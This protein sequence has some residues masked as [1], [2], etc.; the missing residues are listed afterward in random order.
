MDSIQDERMDRILCRETFSGAVFVLMEPF[1]QI[2]SDANINRT[3]TFA[4]QYVYTRLLYFSKVLD[5]RLRGND[6]GAIR[7]VRLKL[8]IFPLNI[9]A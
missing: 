7:D 2:A 4:G 5:S 8:G 1:N 3:V 6:E 9:F